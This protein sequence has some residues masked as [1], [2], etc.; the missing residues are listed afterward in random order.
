MHEQ[1][2]FLVRIQIYDMRSA[3]SS[4]INLCGV[5]FTDELNLLNN[6]LVHQ[7]YPLKLIT[8]LPLI[9]F[10]SLMLCGCF[11]GAEK[12]TV[13]DINM[14]NLDSSR[15]HCVACCSSSFG[16]F[17]GWGAGICHNLRYSEVLTEISKKQKIF[18]LSI[19]EFS[20]ADLDQISL[21][22]SME[23]SLSF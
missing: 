5:I 8:R 11:G 7:I 15:M 2:K 18:V 22:W 13:H 21:Y 17:R 10:I 6:Y 1:G 3:I 23:R 19:F 14:E 9:F 20:Y 12:P 16:S 4:S